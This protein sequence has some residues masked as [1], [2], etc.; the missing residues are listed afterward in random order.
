MITLIEGSRSVGDLSLFLLKCCFGVISV[1]PH[2]V[3]MRGKLPTENIPIIIMAYI[4]FDPLFLLRDYFPM[5]FTPG[6][7]IYLSIGST[8]TR[9]VK[10][11]VI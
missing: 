6:M 1:K 4:I 8:A 5:D 11:N 2:I 7:V 9:P 10:Q 3:A